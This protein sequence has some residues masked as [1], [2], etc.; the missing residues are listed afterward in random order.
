M[1]LQSRTVQTTWVLADEYC[2]IFLGRDLNRA[3]DGRILSA[4]KRSVAAAKSLGGNAQHVLACL[5]T[6]ASGTSEYTWFMPY[7]SFAAKWHYPTPV[8]FDVL[9]Y[10]PVLPTG[11]KRSDVNI[12]Q[13]YLEIQPMP[14]VYD[15]TAYADWVIQYG[16]RAVAHG[17]WDGIYSFQLTEN[18]ENDVIPPAK[19][20]ELVGAVLM[21][22]SI[23]VWQSERTARGIQ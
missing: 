19:L 17:K 22:R 9:F 5:L 21:Q 6:L 4:A 20:C 12:L 3:V 18:P 13:A 7:E 11:Q 15:R 23:E 14:A 16:S 1:T 2:K 8:S 10:N